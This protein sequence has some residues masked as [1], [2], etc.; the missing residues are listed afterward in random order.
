MVAIVTMFLLNLSCP[1]RGG[2]S[3]GEGIHLP[4]S[5]VTRRYTLVSVVHLKRRVQRL[6]ALGLR[7]LVVM[8]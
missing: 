7:P 2:E 1:R 4:G 6:A 8:M 3:G 5:Y